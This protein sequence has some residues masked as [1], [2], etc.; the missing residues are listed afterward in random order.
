MIFARPGIKA[1]NFNI[2]DIKADSSSENEITVV[3]TDSSKLVNNPISLNP[4]T[5]NKQSDFEQNN[6]RIDQ[7][8]LISNQMDSAPDTL[9]SLPSLKWYSMFTNIPGDMVKFYDREITLDNIPI[10]GGIVVL[11]AGAIITDG[12]TLK[13]SK[14]FNK[15]MS[16]LF[17]WVGDG[18]TQ[19]GLAAAFAA[20]GFISSDNRALI[21]CSQIVEAVLA[22]GAVVQV[23]KHITGRQSPESATRTSGVWRFF[24]NQITYLKHVS[25]YDAFPSG[26]LTTSLATF[27]VIAENY[28]EIKWIKP[29][30]YGI[31]ALLA[32]SMVSTGIHWFSDYPLAVF[33]GY[34]FGEIISHPLLTGDNANKISNITI[35]PYLGF[36]FNGISLTYSF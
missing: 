13:A 29:V 11:T 10:Y 19:F 12:Q 32:V 33:L 4:Q 8:T 25:T 28:P 31:E 26:H 24:P 14:K 21:T 27:I 16:D 9:N 5:L 36:T 3:K 7:K 2:S 15:N 34:T 35:S 22:S 23:L 20:Y 17:V 6:L 30:S 1:D 18:R